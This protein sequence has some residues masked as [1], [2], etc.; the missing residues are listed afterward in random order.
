[1]KQLTPERI[2]TLK[3]NEV[4]VFGSN[5][6]GHH[7][8]GAA[9]Q[10]WQEFGAK[11]GQAEGLS[12]N[13]Y[14]IP[15]MRYIGNKAERVTEDEFRESLYNFVKFAD[16]N[17]NLIFYVTKIGCGIAGWHINEVK[18]LFWKAIDRISPDPES[19]FMP[20]NIFV[21]KEFVLK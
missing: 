3:P 9:Y 21:P 6:D 5:T 14:A 11:W 17:R 7:Y 8:G 20:S 4:F 16:E 12:G 13:T 2:K 10:A 19:G 1:M 18:E 15:T